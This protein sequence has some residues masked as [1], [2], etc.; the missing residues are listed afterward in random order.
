MPLEER[1][2]EEEEGFDDFIT[3]SSLDYLRICQESRNTYH[4][5]LVWDSTLHFF[6]LSYV[7]FLFLSTTV[8]ALFF[9]QEFYWDFE[10]GGQRVAE[11]S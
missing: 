10:L 6:F 8:R 5:K 7:Q 4:K 3:F 1:S 9:C 11:R 2:D